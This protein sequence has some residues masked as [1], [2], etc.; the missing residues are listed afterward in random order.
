MARRR[1]DGQTEVWDGRT[2]Q[3][4]ANPKYAATAP[5]CG[6]RS[7]CMLINGHGVAGSGS[8]PES[9]NG[10]TWRTWW[11]QTKRCY[12][13]GSPCGLYDVSCGTATDCLAVGTNWMS[14]SDQDATAVR[15][16]RTKWVR[17]AF[18]LPISIWGHSGVLNQVSCAGTFCMTT[19]TAEVDCGGGY[20][21]CGTLAAAMT[22][23]GRTG[24]WTDVSPKSAFTCTSATCAWTRAISCGS[25]ANCMTF[26]YQN[27]N[28]AW[29]GTS[30]NAAPFAPAGRGAALTGLSC[31]QAFC[32][33]VG[34]QV[35]RGR[36]VTLAEYWNGTTW[37][38]LTTPR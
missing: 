25:P 22:W 30:W 8:V 10:R 5:S 12:G 21:V 29:N 7:L 37:K 11:R 34:H 18:F 27:G 15:W 24:S 6:S 17:M 32:M 13:N 2:W 19:G 9:W 4:A 20:P 38:I 35:V 26:T 1:L 31:H 3:A 28:L 16:D 33:A 14:T 23:N 36:Y